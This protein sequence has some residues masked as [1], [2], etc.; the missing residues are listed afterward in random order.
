MDKNQ[1]WIEF[2]DDL[3][4]QDLKHPHQTAG[5]K[6]L[7]PEQWRELVVDLLRDRVCADDAVFEAGCGVLA[8]LREVQSLIMGVSI[9]GMEPALA[10]MERVYPML[11][12]HERERFFVG[13]LPGGCAGLPD[14]AYDVTLCNSVLQYMDGSVIEASIRE[15]LRITKLGRHLI[16]GGICDPAYADKIEEAVRTNWE[17]SAID[18]HALLAR[19]Y[20]DRSWWAR[21]ET[22]GYRV[23]IHDRHI[24]SLPNAYLRYNVHIGT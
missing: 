6:A 17:G 24:P 2:F 19:T 11:A 16:L 8:L 9:A 7:G 22:E 1:N 4:G 20:I 3:A 5:W 21:F 10:V 18:G 13:R 12:P 15:L 23:E 14:R